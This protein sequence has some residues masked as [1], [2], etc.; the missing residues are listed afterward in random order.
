MNVLM[1]REID[2]SDV[3]CSFFKDTFVVRSILQKYSKIIINGF[4]PEH[5]AKTDGFHLILS[6]HNNFLMIDLHSVVDLQT[7][8][9]QYFL[10][11]N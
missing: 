6:A 4:I 1:G 10:N 11:N 9:N 3:T 7:V 8:A 2:Q 5:I